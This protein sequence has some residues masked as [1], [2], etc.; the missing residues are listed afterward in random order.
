MIR[1]PNI[2]K[3]ALVIKRGH[4]HHCMVG[5]I[6]EWVRQLRLLDVLDN[7]TTDTLIGCHD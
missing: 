1:F 5:D 2:L 7:G 6:E 4:V 3:K